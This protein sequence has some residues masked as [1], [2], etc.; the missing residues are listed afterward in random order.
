MLLYKAT[1]MPNTNKCISTPNVMSNYNKRKAFIVNM[2]LLIYYFKNTFIFFII[3]FT[4][5]TVLVVF[6]TYFLVF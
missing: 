3:N 5:Y 6:G 1:S 2:F 4:V